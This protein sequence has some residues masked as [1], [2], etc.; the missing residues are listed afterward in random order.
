[1]LNNVVFT[2]NNPQKWS[3]VK[4]GRFLAE[5]EFYEYT[6][7]VGDI[8]HTPHWQ[9]WGQ[10]YRSPSTIQTKYRCFCQFRR[11]NT[12]QQRTYITGVTATTPIRTG[13]KLDDTVPNRKETIPKKRLE[14]VTLTEAYERIRTAAHRP[15]LL[16]KESPELIRHEKLLWRFWDLQLGD[17]RCRTFPRNVF[18]MCG[19]SRLGKSKIANI[20]ATYCGDVYALCP[21][22]NTMWWTN[23]CQQQTVIAEE[24]AGNMKYK[25]MLALLDP[26]YNTMCHRRAGGEMTWMTADTVIIT[27]DRHPKDWYHNPRQ[28]GKELLA[29]VTTWEVK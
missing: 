22:D 23:Y 1:M 9:G 17:Q 8:K 19:D 12:A 13:G 27:S 2:V 10:T 21:S 15:D 20:I 18:V 14:S 6:L 29:R 16:L 26:W 25:T 11:G 28:N 3:L 4:Q 24:F 5:F 7:Q